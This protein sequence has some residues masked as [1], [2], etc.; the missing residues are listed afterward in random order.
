[1]K[2]EVF[3][4]TNILVYAFSPDEPVKQTQSLALI[5]AKDW[6]ISWQVI[7]EFSN[8]ALHKF[9]TPMRPE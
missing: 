6:C 8:V 9:K 3:P 4:D 5:S 2:A 7:Q 1:M